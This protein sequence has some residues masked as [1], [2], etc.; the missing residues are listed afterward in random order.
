MDEKNLDQLQTIV[1]RLS[2]RQALDLL[3]LVAGSRPACLVMDPGDDLKHELEAFCEKAGFNFRLEE[4][5]SGGLGKQGLFITQNEKRL[6]KL[7]DSEGRFYGLSDRHVGIFLGF[8]EEDVEYF[9]RN[10]SDG[11]VEPETRQ[12]KSEM[13]SDGEISEK[14][15]EIVKLVSYVPEPSRDG[16][17]R[18]LRRGKLHL[19]SLETFD[20]EHGTSI[21]LR[22]VEN[23]YRGKID[24]SDL[25]G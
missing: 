5:S 9:H 6:E 10:I 19:E 14:E 18:A 23:F 24:F 13:V 21:G 7:E 15:S 20:R 8:P 16:I 2:D 25:A 1:E 22:V 3:L 4:D 12:R 17:I 11:P